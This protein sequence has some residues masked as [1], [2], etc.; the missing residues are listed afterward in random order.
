MEQDK[1]TK[2]QEAQPII[3]KGLE[4]SESIY[5]AHQRLSP[6]NNNSK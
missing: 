6:S 5:I 3:N 2:E 1:K 4:G